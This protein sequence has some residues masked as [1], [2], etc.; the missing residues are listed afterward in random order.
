ME[1]Y[2]QTRKVYLVRGE[3]RMYTYRCGV[4]VREGSLTACP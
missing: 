1:I 2:S 3:K 4:I